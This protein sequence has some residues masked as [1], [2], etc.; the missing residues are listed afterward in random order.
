MTDYEQWKQWLDRWKVFYTEREHCFGKELSVSGLHCE[1][2][3]EF[4]DSGKFKELT[5]EE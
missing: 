4:D 1:A 2:L 3:I 5:A